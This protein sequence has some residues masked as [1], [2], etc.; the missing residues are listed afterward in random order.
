MSQLRS[1]ILYSCKVREAYKCKREVHQLHVAKP[2]IPNEHIELK[3]KNNRNIS[4][5]KYKENDEI[6]N[7]DIEIIYQ[8]NEAETEKN[9]E[10]QFENEEDYI[11]SSSEWNNDFSF[12]GCTIHP[13]DNKNAKWPLDSL[14]ILELEPSL[15]LDNNQIFTN[16]K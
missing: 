1:N 13:A 8:D 3:N 9:H 15:F 5:N 2:I 7:K 10:N 4:S 11:F 16:T 14:Y 12:A 6:T